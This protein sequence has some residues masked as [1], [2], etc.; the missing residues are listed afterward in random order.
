MEVVY[1]V[2][3]LEQ[4]KKWRVVSRTVDI[5]FKILKESTA[6]KERNIYMNPFFLARVISWSRLKTA[7]LLINKFIHDDCRILDFGGGSGVFAKGL[8]NKF[9]KVDII[10]LDASDAKCLKKYLK[11]DGLNII[12]NDIKDYKNK[13]KYEIIVATDVLEHFS[14]TTFPVDFIKKNIENN[15][16][17]VVSLPIENY[18]YRLGRMIIKK[19]KPAD[20]YFN[21]KIILR[22]L[23]NNN[24][25]ILEKR[26]APNFFLAKIPLFNIAI[27]R[28]KGYK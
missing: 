10:D 18:V 20:H 5:D 15:G 2:K 12:E 19:K 14:S 16:L 1:L 21:S 9:S 23:E 6:T 8:C 22:Y 11:L 3:V 26:F 24:F 17:L 7:M 13:N 27:L 28:Y 4:I 25:E